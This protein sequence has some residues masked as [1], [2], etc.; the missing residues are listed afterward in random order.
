MVLSIPDGGSLTAV[1]VVASSRESAEISVPP[2]LSETSTIE[3]SSLAT[4]SE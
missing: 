2:P 3:A 1:T 4:L